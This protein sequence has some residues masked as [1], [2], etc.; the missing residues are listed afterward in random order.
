MIF[1]LDNKIICDCLQPNCPYCGRSIEH[2]LMINQYNKKKLTT[3]K[4]KK[5]ISKM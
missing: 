5:F 2:N 4:Y 3:R 1:P